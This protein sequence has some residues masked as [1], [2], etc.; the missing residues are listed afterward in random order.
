[1]WLCVCVVPLSV[2]GDGHIGGGL[3]FDGF[4]WRLASD[5]VEIVVWWRDGGVGAP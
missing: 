5:A 2:M 3:I 4:R 1:M